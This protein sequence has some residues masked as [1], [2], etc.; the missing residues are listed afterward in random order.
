[1]SRVRISES[2]ATELF[3]GYGHHETMDVVQLLGRTL[4]ISRARRAWR[5]WLAEETST[6]TAFASCFEIEPDFRAHEDVTGADLPVL[7]S[8]P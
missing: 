4:G 7:R 2:E 1:M 5:L 8:I 3:A 6:F